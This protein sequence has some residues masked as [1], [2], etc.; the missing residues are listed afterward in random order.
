[1]GTT[2][3]TNETNLLWETRECAD[4]LRLTVPETGR[5]PGHTRDERWK[6]WLKTVYEDSNFLYDGDFFAVYDEC[7]DKLPGE[8]DKD[9][10]RA[11]ITFL[12]RQMRQEYEPYSCLTSG[13]LLALLNRWIDLAEGANG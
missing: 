4:F 1:M 7:R 9:Q 13:E 10:V 5:H 11:C 3:G 2:T 12:L 6:A 8:M